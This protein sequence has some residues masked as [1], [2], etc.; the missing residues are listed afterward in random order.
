LSCGVK[1]LR[2]RDKDVEDVDTGEDADEYDEELD[3]MRLSRNNIF[4]RW[5]RWLG[6]H[7]WLGSPYPQD[8]CTLFWGIIGRTLL[9]GIV[10][11]CF[12][13]GL[14]IT[15]VS[16]VLAFWRHPAFIVGAV[17]AGVGIVAFFLNAR[18]ARLWRDAAQIV[19][20]KVDSVK[21]RYCPHIEWTD[22]E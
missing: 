1:T 16:L 14:G 22:D 5:Y 19:S 17:A 7:R 9:L 20:G 8:F 11:T 15:L 4:V 2:T 18:G 6:S 10:C 3:W 13:T 12:L 21:N